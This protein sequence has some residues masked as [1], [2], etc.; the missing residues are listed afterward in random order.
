MFSLFLYILFD[1]ELHALLVRLVFSVFLYILF[2]AVLHSPLDTL[3]FFLFLV[4]SVLCRVTC[5]VGQA[6]VFRVFVHTV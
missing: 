4:H 6:C 3:V 1:A 2:D 5:T